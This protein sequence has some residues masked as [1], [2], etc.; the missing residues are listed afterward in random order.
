MNRK[1][2]HQKRLCETCHWLFHVEDPESESTCPYCGENDHSP[3]ICF[4]LDKKYGNYKKQLLWTESMLQERDAL[5]D[6]LKVGGQ[7]KA[8]SVVA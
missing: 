1:R 4:R 6:S 7:Y 5:I 2:C 3:F 8:R